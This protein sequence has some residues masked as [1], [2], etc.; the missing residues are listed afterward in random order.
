MTEAG[1]GHC[2]YQYLACN[3]MYKKT[4][5]VITELMIGD[6]RGIERHHDK[7]QHKVIAY[8]GQHTHPANEKT[9]HNKE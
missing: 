6:K 1:K 9:T 7:N 4:C 2:H 5:S 8:C 3:H